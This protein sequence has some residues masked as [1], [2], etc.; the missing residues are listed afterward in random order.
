MFYSLLYDVF[1]RAV[2]ADAMLHF[3]RR[4]QFKTK[5]EQNVSSLSTVGKYLWRVECIPTTPASSVLTIL[6][7]IWTPGSCSFFFKKNT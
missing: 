2:S 5:Y 3:L 1:T 4:C 7:L 6:D